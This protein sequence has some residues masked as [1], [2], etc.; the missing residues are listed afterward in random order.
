MY[1]LTHNNKV[2]L[3]PINWNSRMFN[4][5]IEEDLE[6][7]TNILPSNVS[8]VPLDLG[9]N[10]KIREVKEVHEPINTKI[11]NY[12]SPVWTFTNEFGIATYVAINK[13]IDFIKQELKNELAHARWVKEESGTKV[14]IQGKEVTVDTARGFRDIF[15]QQYLL[16]PENGTTQWKFPEGWL[17]LSKAELGLCVNAGVAH[18][19]SAF[20]WEAGMIA[21]ID[22]STTSAEL[23]AIIFV[24]KPQNGVI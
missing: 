22:G 20:G 11:Q 9:N 12:S 24:E 18:V 21:V 14:T 17:V 23:D 6:I 4:S 1:V 5:I 2:L 15:V 16:L 19:Q 13:S 10:I 7:T 8:N 3:G